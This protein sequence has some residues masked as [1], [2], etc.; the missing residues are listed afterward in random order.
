MGFTRYSA[1]LRAR[2]SRH[3]TSVTMASSLALALLAVMAAVCCVRGDGDGPKPTRPT[4]P[5]TCPEAAQRAAE[6]CENL[7][8][9][10]ANC[11]SPDCVGDDFASKQCGPRGCHCVE[12]DGRP[13]IN[14]FVPIDAD[15]ELDCDALP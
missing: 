4:M 15:T 11:P 1:V 12:P 5:P 7:G 14:S 8:I 6:V 2:P 10:E 9:A 13:V 3:V